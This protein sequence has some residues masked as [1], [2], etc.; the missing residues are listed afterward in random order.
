MDTRNTQIEAQKEVI[1]TLREHM[2][3]YK[4][5]IDHYKSR[6]KELEFLLTD[7]LVA[8]NILIEDIRGRFDGET[9]E[10]IENILKD[11]TEAIKRGYKY[12]S[13]DI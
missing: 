5:D 10:K 4:L 9:R 1:K 8:T 3:E 7:R 2:G 13:E 11:N 6:A 12:L